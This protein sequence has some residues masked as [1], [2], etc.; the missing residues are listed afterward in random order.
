MNRTNGLMICLLGMTPL[1]VEAAPM[2]LDSFQAQTTVGYPTQYDRVRF[3]LVYEIGA[4]PEW[5]ILEAEPAL[6]WQGGE[7]GTFDLSPVNATG[8][9]DF[10]SHLTDDVAE[11]LAFMSYFDDNTGQ[12]IAGPD[13]DLVPSLL[14]SNIEL[15][16]CTV[17]NVQF[18]Q[19]GST[20]WVHTDAT[21]DFWGTPEPS[22]GLLILAVGGLVLR[23]RR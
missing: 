15:I 3:A 18:W 14:G 23:R 22:T 20:Y 10:T 13:G 19:D 11:I 7:T 6:Y 2:L 17:N 5:L 1:A 16:R 8:F 4:P 12:A 9:D 21:W